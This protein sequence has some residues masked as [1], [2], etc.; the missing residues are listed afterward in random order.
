[1]RKA[2]AGTARS[3]TVGGQGQ[4]RNLCFESLFKEFQVSRSP[5]W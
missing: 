4:T 3:M 1:M 5:L 2:T